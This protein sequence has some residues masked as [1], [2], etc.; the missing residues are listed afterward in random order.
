[1]K[2]L[3]G[4]FDWG[5][6]HAT[7]DMPLI[8]KLL[9]DKNKVDILSTGKA[10]TLLKSHFGKKCRYFD[11]PSIY[12][13]YN[14]KR[15]F[16]MHF[17]F[18]TPKLIKSLI[19]AR[20]HSKNIVKRGNYEKIISDCRY[21]LYDKQSNSYLI[22]HQLRFMA[23]KGI[24]RF[25]EKWLSIQMNHYK[26]VIVPDYKKN[27]LS[28]NLSHN[29]NYLDKKKIKYIGVISKLKK[30]KNSKKDVDYFISLSGPDEMKKKLL[31]RVMEQASAINGKIIIAGGEPGMSNLKR[32]KNMKIYGFLK[33]G[34]QEKIMNR[35][36]FVIAR[37]GYTTIM[38]LAEIGV[39][40]VLL[41]PSPGQTE[42]E[43]LVKYYER[44]K[45]YHHSSQHNIDLKKEV[46]ACKPFNGFKAPWKTK[47]SIKKFMQ[48]ILE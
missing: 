43:Y 13:I 15:Y 4:V 25:L 3:F 26:Y 38:E 11:V 24:Q 48:V 20:K 34:E 28:G 16:K 39:K 32:I 41:I 17:L 22:N 21:D 9:K 31:K 35:A 46:K 19:T 45:Y 42:Q 12:Y 7:R 2:I 27:S 36:K 8:E 10:L 6:G 30:I 44:E 18:S 37:A 23:P 29:L 14:Y 47:S 40:K 5:L 1:M 33:S